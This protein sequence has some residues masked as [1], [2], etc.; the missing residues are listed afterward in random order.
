[1]KNTILCLISVVCLSVLI[2]TTQSYAKTKLNAN[3]YGYGFVF[4]S[5][6]FGDA[7]TQDPGDR[8]VLYDNR[9][10]SPVDVSFQVVNTGKSNL[11]PEVNGLP[12]PFVIP[13]DGDNR[14]PRIMRFTVNPGSTFR[15]GAQI[16]DCKWFAIINP[17]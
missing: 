3:A 4:E 9:G 7:C 10:S 15:L 11:F 2:P 16:S 17:H 5:K 1:M 6:D 14:R 12:T 13:P 8:P